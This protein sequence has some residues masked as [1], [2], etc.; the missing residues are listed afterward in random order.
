[1]KSI[2][3]T[4]GICALLTSASQI[5]AQEEGNNAQNPGLKAGEIKEVRA[6]VQKIDR[7]TREVT[8]KKE[9]GTMVTIKAPDTVRNFDQI[10]VGD[11]L[12]AKYSQS[13]ALSVRK[14]DEP[15]S[16]TGRESVARAPLGEKPAGA[17]RSTI[18]ITATIQSINRDTREVTL[19]GPEG[20]TKVVKVPEDMKK[21]DQLKEG[22][23]VVVKATESLAISVSSPEK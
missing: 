9:D 3:A 12:T 23:Q 20:K 21:F 6:T 1:M 16:A 4:M 10:K 17:A 22:D 2:I 14:S 15:P 8:L 7:D 19:V 13:I 18:Q 11:I 5:I